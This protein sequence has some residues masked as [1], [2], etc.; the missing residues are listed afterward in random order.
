MPRIEPLLSPSGARL[1]A[2]RGEARVG[3]DSVAWC[4]SVAHVVED[5]SV[6]AAL[7]SGWLRGSET[8][9]YGRYVVDHGRRDFLA[10]RLAAKTALDGL[11]PTSDP[12]LAW[13]IVPGAWSRPIVRGPAAGFALTLA[14]AG[15]IGVA[16]AHDDRWRCGIDIERREHQ[17][18]D[19]IRTQLTPAETAW[20]ET[21]PAMP[22]QEEDTSARWFA[23]WTAREAFGKL[24]GTGLGLPEALLPTSDWAPLGSGWTAALAGNNS[25]AI[26]TAVDARVV[27]SLAMPNGSLTLETRAALQAW[28]ADA[29]RR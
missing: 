12:G 20:A 27:V 26:Q 10:G 17:A 22:L 23:L 1:V 14:H 3:D 21:K 18:V 28:F 13:E 29:L 25:F 16:I 11:H 19:T 8:T 15:G 5:N 2:F 24:L 7:A 4:A 6:H 9:R